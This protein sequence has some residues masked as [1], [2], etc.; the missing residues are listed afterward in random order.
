MPHINGG[1]YAFARR[2]FGDFAGFL[3]AWG[4]WISVWTSN[5]AI[6]VSF[7]SSMSTFFPA[8]NGNPAPS[9]LTG[10]GA[11]WLLTWVNS[12]GV[13]ASGRMQLVTTILKLIPLLVIALGGLF[14][15]RFR[16]FVP[17]NIS[18]QSDFSAITTTA[19]TTFFA[20]LGIECATIPAKSVSNPEKTIPRATIIGTLITALVYM[21]GTF[22]L[23]GIIAPKDLQLS[24]TPFADAASRI[25]GNSARY[26]V[27]AG[28]AVATFGTLNGWLLIQGQLP[29]AVAADQLFPKVFSRENK[30]GVPAAG[31]IIGS[32]LVS[33]LMMMNYT[34]G[35]VERFRFLI[36][37]STLT[38]LVPYL[39]SVAAY[40]IIR[41]ENK[42]SDRKGFVSSLVLAAAAFI[43]GFW[44]IAGS[45]EETVYWGFL[46]LLTGIPFYLWVTRNKKH[47][48]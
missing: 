13:V 23:M 10:L 43:F 33:G 7:V 30:K 18:S 37:L 39:F 41:L 8:L 19:T 47:D 20:F 11:I 16:N 6:A 2:G 31:M 21:L 40:V 44:V 32:L 42:S 29:A 1:P 3:I 4:Y 35:L 48:H 45:G 15:I 24:V 34:K 25:W 9:I 12:R 27:S 38:C 28:A 17:F 22:C 5:A 14:F 26:W 46:A 36:L